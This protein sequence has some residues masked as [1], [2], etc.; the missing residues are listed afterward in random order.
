M[1]AECFCSGS[2]DHRLGSCPVIL[3]R[4]IPPP[5]ATL[6]AFAALYHSAVASL[7]NQRIRATRQ[8]M[9]I[10]NDISVVL[11]RRTSRPVFHIGLPGKNAGKRARRLGS[12]PIV[13]VGQSWQPGPCRTVLVQ[14]S[15]AQVCPQCHR[16]ALIR[17]QR[18]VRAP[19]PE[20][21]SFRGVSP[22]PRELPKGPTSVSWVWE[23]TNPRNSFWRSAW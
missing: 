10:P 7:A 23:G 2:A 22:H 19:V 15:Q 17:D 3:S 14:G 5:T 1:E 9:P 21:F 8:T 18:P 20:D 11:F 4:P 6:H 16:R 12:F 13:L